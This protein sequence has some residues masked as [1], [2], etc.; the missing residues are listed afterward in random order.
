MEHEQTTGLMKPDSVHDSEPV[1]IISAMQKAEIDQLVATA[2][3]F[4]R[5]S[6][7]ATAEAVEMAR[8][9]VETAESCFYSLKR[10]NKDGTEKAIEGPS[11]R[12]AEIVAYCWGN[13]RY[14]SQVLGHDGKHVIG[15]GFCHDLQKNIAV[16]IQT[17]RRI[18]DSGG[19]T[20]GDDMI[21][22]TG[23][24]AAAIARRQAIF[25]AIPMSLVRQVYLQ[26]RDLAERQTGTTG[27]RWAKVV[28][29]F[30]ALGVTGDQLLAYLG[31]DS[32]ED[33]TPPDFANLTGV[34]NAIRDGETTVEEQFGDGGRTRKGPGTKSGAV[35][36]EG[37]KLTKLEQLQN[38][39]KGLGIDVEGKTASQLATAIKTAREIEAKKAQKASQKPQE[40]AGPTIEDMKAFLFKV[41]REGPTGPMKEARKEAGLDPDTIKA[42]VASMEEGKIREYYKL[43]KAAL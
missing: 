14:G 32:V 7:Q 17:K 34:R 3:A 27:D 1:Q 6:R 31:K 25:G 39:A 37:R 23:N 40:E 26:A 24:A 11:V 5:N 35:S 42:S 29:V 36:G 28:A 12:C 41:E 8:M 22:V 18:T 43:L 30:D 9:D 38:E 10:H 2:Q 13:L 19:R 20:Y 15:E 21:T 16:R 4:P 33:V